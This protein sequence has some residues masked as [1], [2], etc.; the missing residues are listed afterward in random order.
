MARITAKDVAEHAGVSR[1]TVS[2][3]INNK[4]GGAVR[5]TDA[6]R[7]RVWKAVK[8]LGFSPSAAAVS[9]RT[10][11]SN[12]V[13]I[14]VPHIESPYHPLFA[15]VVQ[16]RAEL[17]NLDVL[18]YSTR[19]DYERERKFVDVLIGR[20]V[21]GVMIH[22]YRLTSEDLE[23]VVNAD[24]ST[25]V[26][27][28]TPTHPKVDNI[29]F[30]ERESVRD[31]VIQIASRGHRRIGQIAGPERS[32]SG[33]ER[34]LGY[35][36]GLSAAGLPLDENLIVA[37]DFYREETANAAM[38]TLLSLDKSPTAVFA[39]SDALAATAILYCTDRNI[40]VPNDMAIV[41][42]DG[43]PLARATR[44]ELTTIRKDFDLLG[45]KCVETLMERIK[46]DHP[47]PRRKIVL[48]CEHVFRRSL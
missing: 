7:K 5:I 23:R 12:L 33:Q 2:Y 31:M 37:A 3:V 19:D 44:P 17:F 28:P 47:L 16:N 32:W 14:M 22:S 29:V 35:L 25:V 43:L 6:T 46:S 38:E 13:S 41:G 40:R 26:L 8:E 24:V 20:Q 18:I 11:R 34:H 36:D 42:M 1:T 45:T 4:S 9:L 10:R 48:P 39:A 21:D 15:S 27:G 30:N